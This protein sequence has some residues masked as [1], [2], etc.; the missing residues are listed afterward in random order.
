MSTQ[1]RLTV[2]RYQNTNTTHMNKQHTQIDETKWNMLI[3]FLFVYTSLRLT[4]LQINTSE[5]NCAKKGKART[6]WRPQVKKEMKKKKSKTSNGIHLH[7]QQQRAIRKLPADFFIFNSSAES[8]WIKLNWIQKIPN[9]KNNV[10]DLC[11]EF[12]V[13]FRRF[14]PTHVQRTGCN[15]HTHEHELTNERKKV[16]HPSN[17]VLN[18]VPTSA[19]HIIWFNFST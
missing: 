18:D 14:W 3:V 17:K 12:T 8:A 5:W 13:F 19:N 7:L 6:K 1:S 2:V 16:S 15:N 10:F 11:S 4:S 9:G